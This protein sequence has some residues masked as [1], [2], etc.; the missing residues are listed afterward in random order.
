MATTP[1]YGEDM[2]TNN[3]DFDAWG[4]KNN[5]LHLAWDSAL[6]APTNTIKGRLTA[7]TG[8]HENLTPTQVAT[9]LP[10]VVGDGGGG[11]TKGLVPAPAA[12]DA[13]A[14]K[15]LLASGGWGFA[16]ARA[17]GRFNGPAGTTVV[18]RGV[19]IS[20]TGVGAYTVTLSPVL[21]DT[22]YIIQM[23][24]ESTTTGEA[25]GFKVTSKSNSGFVLETFVLGS[26]AYDPPFFAI[27]ILTV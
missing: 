14:G 9:M 24:P 3:A 4:T 11:G 12:G 27:V 6:G 25:V 17:I 7:G 26:T 13:A 23:T 5:D 22:N 15:A 18:A 8:P 2:P 16:G 19:S 21:G 10:A 1:V 20:R